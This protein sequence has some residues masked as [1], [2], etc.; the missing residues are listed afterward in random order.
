[1]NNNNNSIIANNSNKNVMEQSQN[2]IED[3]R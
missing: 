1:M 2:I 3:S